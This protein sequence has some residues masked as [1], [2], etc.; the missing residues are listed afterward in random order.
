MLALV[1]C[2]VSDGLRPSEATVGVPDIYDNRQ[3]L[4][5]ERDFLHTID[6]V[7][8]ITIGGVQ[9]DPR[10]PYVLVELPHEADSGANRL[11]VYRENVLVPNGDGYAPN[12]WSSASTREGT[13]MIKILCEQV[14]RGLREADAILALRDFQGRR[15][16]LQIEKD[17]L[18]RRDGKTYLPVGFVHR[19]APTG[20]FLIEL[21]HEAETGV[22]RLWVSAEKV[23]DANEVLA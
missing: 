14:S 12:D 3:Y 4:R 6:G 17:F 10:Q 7:S 15:H 2:E 16:F 1:S 19:D 8:Y 5:V 13:S 20:A 22:H 21:P 9:D 11:W 18:F 23:L